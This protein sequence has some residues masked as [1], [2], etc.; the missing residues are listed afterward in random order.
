M[1]A[2][3]ASATLCVVLVVSAFCD[4]VNRLTAFAPP[5][6]YQKILIFGSYEPANRRKIHVLCTGLVHFIGL[7]ILFAI[8]M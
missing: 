1:F 8:V 6:R 2:T 4:S 5:C 3:F 7:Q